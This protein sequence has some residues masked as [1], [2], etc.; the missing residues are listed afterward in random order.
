MA[1]SPFAAWYF[2]HAYHFFLWR[3]VLDVMGKLGRAFPKY[4]DLRK[5]KE[6]AIFKYCSM[7]LTPTF[8]VMLIDWVLE[9]GRL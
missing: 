6:E 7:Q 3:F 9:I 2:G 1:A 5:T 4:M 8:T